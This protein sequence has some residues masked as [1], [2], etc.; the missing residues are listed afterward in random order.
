MLHEDESCN[1]VLLVFA[2]KPDLPNAMT[3]AKISD[4]L[5]LHSPRPRH[6]NI[7]NTC[8]PAVYFIGLAILEDPPDAAQ[9]TTTRQRQASIAYDTQASGGMQEAVLLR[10]S[11]EA[12][13]FLTHKEVQYKWISLQSGSR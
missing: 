4:Q 5:G 12:T 6:W 9:C 8:A 7:E 1:T 11:A 10:N 2:S 13:T 3:V